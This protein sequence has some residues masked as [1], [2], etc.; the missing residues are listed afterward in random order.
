MQVL[1]ETI[2][3]TA[4]IVIFSG[5][6]TGAWLFNKASGGS[7]GSGGSTALAPLYGFL[8]C[9]PPDAFA[10]CQ[11]CGSGDLSLT[12]GPAFTLRMSPLTL[13]ANE[14]LALPIHTRGG[15]L[16]A[17]LLLG[18]PE[19]PCAANPVEPA[20]P[21][22][23]AAASGTPTTGL[24]LPPPP[25]SPALYA[26]GGVGSAAA[27]MRLALSTPPKAEASPT[28]PPPS[29][30]S[31]GVV[32]APAASLQLRTSPPSPTP[33]PFPRSL[34]RGAASGLVSGAGASQGLEACCGAALGTELRLLQ[35]VVGAAGVQLLG[36]DLAELERLAQFLGY[37]LLG[38][39]GH[40]AFLA[41][42]GCGSRSASSAA[43]APAQAATQPRPRPNPSATGYACGPLSLTT[44]ATLYDTPTSG[45][46]PGASCSRVYSAAGA[47]G[48]AAAAA[49]GPA[50]GRPPPS[51]LVLPDSSAHV[52][53]EQQPHRDVM[54]AGTLLGGVSPGS[55]ILCVEGAPPAAAANGATALGMT[56][57]ASAAGGSAAAAVS[58][59]I[60]DVL[61]S[62]PATP[63]RFHGLLEDPALWGTAQAPSSLQLPPSPL[64]PGA[65]ATAGGAAG[66]VQLALYAVFMESLPPGVL[67]AAA[68]EL[69][70]LSMLLFAAIRAAF[71]GSSVLGCRAGHDWRSL[72]EQ[73]TGK[74]AAAGSSAA[75]A[76]ATGGGGDTGPAFLGPLS[77]MNS[78]L[79]KVVEDGGREAVGGTGGP[80]G[81]DGSSRGARAV[82]ARH[83]SP[84]G[85]A[86]AGRAVSRAISGGKWP[87]GPL[88]VLQRRL[89][90]A[91]PA[92]AGGGSTLDSAPMELVAEG[93]VAIPRSA[94]IS[95]ALGRKASGSNWA[96]ASAPDVMLEEA[97]AAVA[98]GDGAVAPAA[99]AGMPTELL[100]RTVRSRLTAA[101][102]AQEGS[103]QAKASQ[104]QDLAAVELL[105]VLGRGGQGVVFRGTLHGL[106]AAIKVL[107][108]QP[109]KNKDDQPKQDRQ[110]QRQQ[111]Q[112][113]AGGAGLGDDA[114][115]DGD[116]DGDGP[117]SAV[118][119]T[120]C[121]QAKRG[122]MEVAVAT[123][124]SHPN[125]VQVY[126]AFSGVVVVRC[127]YRGSTAPVL[128]LCAAN[129]PLLSGSP[130][131]PLNQVLCLEYCDAGTL[132][133]AARAGVFRQA[134][135]TGPGNG[136]IWPSLVPLYTS[137]LE[138]ALAL[139]YLHSRGLVHCDV[140]AANVLL[141]GSARDP[142]G[143][144]CKLSDF[145]CVRL[146]NEADPDGRPCFRLKHPLGTVGHMAPEC[147]MKGAF[148]GTEVDVYAFGILMW[149]ILMCRTPYSDVNPQDVPRQV[150][151][152]HL[153]PAFHPLAPAPYCGLA[154]RCWSGSPRRRPTSA[155]LVAEIQ[156]LL[157][158]AQADARPRSVQQGMPR[159]SAEPP[160]LAAL[161]AAQSAAA[162]AS[163]AAAIPPT[164]G[165]AAARAHGRALAAELAAQYRR[166]GG[167]A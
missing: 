163:A 155:D 20:P 6:D 153:R 19:R 23:A 70:P 64:V 162:T 42:V 113:Q 158:D 141:K 40:A 99:A 34:S 104:G 152:A 13:A 11:A 134:C 14:L 126:A 100:I 116:G 8:S 103:E 63:E 108:Q 74:A 130:P 65:A 73:L 49:T 95:Q 96:L 97:A 151:R 66:P 10:I 81:D 28:S 166:G 140:K 56:A 78:G 47:A 32:A 146:M 122:A 80:G 107:V 111:Q 117:G 165:S 87:S 52:M 106:E 16:A 31:A 133:A 39:P 85:S 127:H 93:L 84:G 120:L 125:V 7:G 148:L 131:G 157:S 61:S 112:Q 17:A 128:R 121:R 160:P 142:R 46:T 48:G 21:L 115:G 3:A 50:P 57:A 159:P 69:Q 67:N 59:T 76:A 137:L 124:L 58:G 119:D 30:A 54:L 44:G 90:L 82:S 36:A 55:I 139:R 132:L 161:A 12:H 1:E 150:L 2:A 86:A 25:A 110:Q 98:S 41:Q 118:S 33:L 4:S 38:D 79:D 62:L 35:S 88:A 22:P 60:V 135:A 5:R 105:E 114:C 26:G 24:S 53:E 145:G 154:L 37:G 77:H 123:T 101:M 91:A 75:A 18:W 149:E 143:W 164:A 51:T 29:G 109:D 83:P 15:Q 94:S 9:K 72:Y 43:Q 138:V 45:T 167:A 89:G 147:F 156:G 92:A 129:D 144:N 71:A 68:A 136:A 102:A 27:P